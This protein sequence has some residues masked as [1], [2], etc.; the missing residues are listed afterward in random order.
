MV[1]FSGLVH[2]TLI[3]VSLGMVTSTDLYLELYPWLV[4]LHGRA[5]LTACPSGLHNTDLFSPTVYVTYLL[6]LCQPKQDLAS[7]GD[8]ACTT[9]PSHRELSITWIKT[10]AISLLFAYL[11]IF[12]GKLEWQ[13]IG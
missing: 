9:E 1:Q 7:L 2:G 12:L 4:I 6:I 8:L 5:Y 10:K 11:E 3:S 13:E